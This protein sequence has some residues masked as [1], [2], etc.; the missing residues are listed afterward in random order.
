MITFSQAAAA[1][2]FGKPHLPF[3]CMQ[4]RPVPFGNK[5]QTHL[6]KEAKMELSLVPWPFQRTTIL[7]IYWNLTDSVYIYSQLS[8]S[9]VDFHF[10][11][12]FMYLVF[13]SSHPYIILRLFFPM[14]PCPAETEVVC[15]FAF[16]RSPFP[17]DQHSK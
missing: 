9:E 12:G 6:R 16:L 14:V 15:I 8:T 4:A 5:H 17:F 1:F 13:R 10:L 7:L 3:P 2:N 11:H